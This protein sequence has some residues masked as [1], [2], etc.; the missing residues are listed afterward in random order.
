MS[1][2]LPRSGMHIPVP[3]DDEDRGLLD[4]IQCPHCGSLLSE[5]EVRSILG[6]FGRAR[7]RQGGSRFV[8]MS[9]EQR[10][11]ESRRVAEIRWARVR[12]AA[13]IDDED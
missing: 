13:K 11:Q 10:S 12:A 6:K 1:K 3:A 5:E 8:K 9:P 2:Q 7:R 4:L